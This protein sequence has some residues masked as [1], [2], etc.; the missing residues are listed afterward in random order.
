V[1]TEVPALAESTSASQQARR[2]WR[3]I[4]S[5]E[6]GLIV[7]L[8]GAGISKNQATAAVFVQRSFSAYLPPIAGWFTL[9][10]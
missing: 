8:T 5:A 10:G 7:A 3:A 9:C 6:A 4:F 1:S 2:S